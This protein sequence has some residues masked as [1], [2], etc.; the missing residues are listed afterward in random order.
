[1]LLRKKTGPLPISNAYTGKTALAG[2]PP[3]G[4]HSFAGLVA[5]PLLP[6][7][8]SFVQNVPPPPLCLPHWFPPPLSLIG[9]LTNSSRRMWAQGRLLEPPKAPPQP[10]PRPPSPAERP[11][12]FLPLPFAFPTRLPPPLPTIF[13]HSLLQVLV[14]PGGRLFQPKK[15]L[16]WPPPCSYSPPLSSIPFPYA[17]PPLSKQNFVNLPRFPPLPPV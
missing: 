8:R 2:P 9:A 12:M 5:P 16:L 17:S 13:P 4:K 1:M 10:P 14:W 6:K 11:K 7:P 3:A 15:L